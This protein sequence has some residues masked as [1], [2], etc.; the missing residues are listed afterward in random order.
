MLKPEMMVIP[1]DDDEE[2]RPRPQANRQ[3][4]RVDINR[5]STQRK[6]FTTTPFRTIRFSGYRSPYAYRG[7]RSHSERHVNN[8]TL[9]AIVNN[10]PSAK[11]KLPIR[12]P[13][14]RSGQQN[15]PVSSKLVPVRM[16]L[17]YLV[18]LFF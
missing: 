1:Y 12:E 16:I 18:E 2:Y 13:R 3:T 6:S 11:A 10:R 17:I 4:P 9:P 5:E 15:Q 14:Y 8:D 7:Q